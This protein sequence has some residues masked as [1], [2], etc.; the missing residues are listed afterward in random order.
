M[1]SHNDE[2][3]ELEQVET[4]SIKSRPIYLFLLVLGIAVAGAFVAVVVVLYGFR[5]LDEA[6]A[7]QEPST[8]IQMPAGQRKLPPEPRL[9]GAPGPEGPTLL[10][11]DEMRIY[12]KEVKAKAESY[13]WIDKPGGIARIPI[14]RAKE[15]IVEKGLPMRSEESIKQIQQAESM[16]KAVSNSD[17][18]AG[19]VLKIQ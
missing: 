12:N 3:N 7:T 9:Q 8:R 5:K 13:S 1:S 15:L 11:L 18:S 6:N 16:R 17:S 4:S 14:E 2:H 19:R 10:P